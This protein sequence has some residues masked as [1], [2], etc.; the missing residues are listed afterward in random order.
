[1]NGRKGTDYMR[2]R[3][4][5]RKLENTNYTI[6]KLRMRWGGER[7]KEQI[8]SDNP[9]DNEKIL[10]V[11]PGGCTCCNGLGSPSSSNS[12]KLLLMGG[13]EKETKNNWGPARDSF[14]RFVINL[15]FNSNHRIAARVTLLHTI[16][17]EH[18]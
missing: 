18:V 9:D 10:V 15:C 2:K 1:M 8:Y 6:Y 12:A 3:V 13:I 4:R 16:T 17:I 5:E 7:G 11:V 14:S